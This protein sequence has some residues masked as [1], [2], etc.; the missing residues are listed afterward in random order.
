MLA[1]QD[2]IAQPIAPA[3]QIEATIDNVHA[4]HVAISVCEF[5]I[6]VYVILVSMHAG[7]QAYT[8]VIGLYFSPC[9]GRQFLQRSKM[10]ACKTCRPSFRLAI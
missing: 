3:M 2:Y 8:V 7:I 10:H 1:F 6:T 5:P 9:K 4:V